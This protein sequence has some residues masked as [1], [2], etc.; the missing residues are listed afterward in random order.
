MFMPSI[1]DDNLFDDWF[2]DDFYMP[3][4]PDMRQ[5]AVWQQGCA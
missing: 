1:I 5:E 2:D 3:Y 4:L